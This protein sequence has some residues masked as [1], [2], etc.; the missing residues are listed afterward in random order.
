MYFCE[1]CL[2]TGEVS[3]G[4]DGPLWKQYEPCP[5]CGG[6]PYGRGEILC[7]RSGLKPRE[8]DDA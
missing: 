8:T 1:T 5:N 6:D 4:E 7:L 3:S 2:D